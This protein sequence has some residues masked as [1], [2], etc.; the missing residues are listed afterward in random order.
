MFVILDA[1]RKGTFARVAALGLALGLSACGP[2]VSMAPSGPGGG[3]VHVALLV[4]SGS[5]QAS[6]DLLAQN[7]ENA[8]RLAIADLD[9]VMRVRRHDALSFA[10]QQESAVPQVPAWHV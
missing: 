6:D 3:T 1:A 2:Q 10:E 5:G 8:A 7:L 4:P 9:G